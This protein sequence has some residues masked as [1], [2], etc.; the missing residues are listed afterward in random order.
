MEP[1]G[2]KLQVRF[3]GISSTMVSRSSFQEFHSA[4]WDHVFPQLDKFGRSSIFILLCSEEQDCFIHSSH[5]GVRRPI[6]GDHPAYAEYVP[7]PGSIL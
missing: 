6:Q 2:A 1:S 5:F 7:T 3:Y 4:I